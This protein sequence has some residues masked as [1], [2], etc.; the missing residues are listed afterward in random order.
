VAGADGAV[1]QHTLPDVLALLSAETPLAFPALAPYQA[2]AWHAFLVQLAG[3]ALLRAGRETPPREAGAWRELLRGLT[4][5]YPD[6]EPWCLVAEDLHCPAFL[7]PPV[8]E[9]QLGG[10][11]NRSGFPDELDVLVTAK[12][13]D[14]KMARMARPAPEHWVFTLV[15]LQTM[16][17]FLG[18]GNYGISRMNGGFASRPAVGLT[19]LDRPAGQFL[20]DVAVLLANRNRLLA[21][22]DFYRPSGGLALL[23]LE[24][25]DG[26]ASLGLKQLDPWY[27]EVCRRVRMVAEGERLVACTT[28]TQVAR[29]AA[30]ELKGMTGDPW[31][32]VDR[33]GAKALTVSGHGFSYRLMQELLFSGNYRWS[34]M[35]ERHPG[36]EGREL[37]V[38]ARA[39]AR[40]QGETD[41]YHERLLPIP[42]HARRPVFMVAAEERDKVGRIA[43]EMVTDAST[44]S[45]RVLRPALFAL[46]QAGPDAIAW[47]HKESEAWSRPWLDRFDDEVDQAFFP[48]LW[49]RLDGAPGEAPPAW[50][51]VLRGGALAV[52]R[53]AAAAVPLSTERH[54]RA[55]AAAESAFWGGFYNAFPDLRPAP[56]ESETDHEQAH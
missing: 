52:L 56:F 13:H 16:Q 4:A 3:L 55:V 47:K 6:D 40:G 28:G 33:K 20:R 19:W 15:S 25:W 41:G 8:P 24:P 10:F 27:I 2:H 1:S 43:Q 22:C 14:L 36:D 29:I 50:P 39:L 49:Q 31:T 37:A 7:Q 18:A 46:C 35:Q 54:Y 12:N 48:H 51:L 38:L 53:A 45:G 44:V 21:D 9:G 42:P 34:L 5:D 32:P 30:K 11:K 17:G 26:T 23:W